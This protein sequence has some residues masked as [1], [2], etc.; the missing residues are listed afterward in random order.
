[1]NNS[2]AERRSPLGLVPGHRAPRLYD[3]VAETV[4]ARRYSIRTQQT[5]CHCVRRFI[6]FQNAGHPAEMAESE[7]NALLTHL[8]VEEEVSASTRNQ[9]LSALPLL[10]RH[11]IGGEVGLSGIHLQ[12][13]LEGGDDIRTGQE[14]LG[15][16]DVKT[17]RS[18][19]MSL[20]AGRPEFAGRSIGYETGGSHADTH[21]PPRS[22]VRKGA[23]GRA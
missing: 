21:K 20:T 17:R 1:M 4:R 2:P 19:H 11:V 18:A 6:H 12:L 15:L 7:I 22:Q 10:C 9:A 8:G 23:N 14:L 16:G 13:I 3:R 5:Y